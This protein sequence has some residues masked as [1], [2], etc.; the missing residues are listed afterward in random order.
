VD[1]DSISKNNRY[2]PDFKVEVFFKDICPN[3]KPYEPVD[4]ICKRCRD[5]LCDEVDNWCLI[6]EVL[7][8]SPF[9]L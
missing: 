6:Q 5:K 9:L 1:P 7:K 8:V 2:P 4:K 3:C